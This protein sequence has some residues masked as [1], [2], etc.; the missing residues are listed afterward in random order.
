MKALSL[1]GFAQ[2][3]G[4]LV[5]GYNGCLAVLRRRRA[6]LVVLATDASPGTQE[7]FLR[8]AREIPVII[9]ANK[10]ALGNAIGKPP[11]AVLCVQNP[12]MA[13]AIKEA[14][15]MNI[16]EAEGAHGEVR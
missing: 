7:T 13:Q 2:A 1:L 10:E 9:F 3:A 4:Q 14:V 6:N 8:A 11:T 5:S 15:N 12:Q 16:A